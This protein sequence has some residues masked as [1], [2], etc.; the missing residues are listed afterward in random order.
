MSNRRPPAL[1]IIPA[2]GGSKRI[3]RKNVR[4]MSGKPLISWAIGVAIESGVFDQVVV[5]TDDHE[6]A[7]VAVSYGATVPFIRPNDLSGDH[8]TTTPV[9]AHAVTELARQGRQADQVCCIYPAAIFVSPLDYIKSRALLAQSRQQAIVTSIVRYPHPIQ[10]ALVLDPDGTVDFIDPAHVQTRTQD[11]PDRWHDAGQFYWGRS[12]TW[13]ASNPTL[14]GA[15][16]Y[17]LRSSQVV[18]IDT[19]EDWERAQHL[20]SGHLQRAP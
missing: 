19:E 11:L 7:E 16:G 20:H 3:P 10:R 15:L 18:D 12:E 5:S 9:I 14:R 13:V 4:L 6:I 1:A 17:P 8:A 2:R